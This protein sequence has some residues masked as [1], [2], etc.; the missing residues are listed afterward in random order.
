M[1]FD[2]YQVTRPP[3]IGREPEGAVQTRPR[4]FGSS[5]ARKTNP[6]MALAL[7]ASE[8]AGRQRKASGSKV[9]PLG[10]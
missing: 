2:M 10:S 1:M 9:T 5:A 7:T 8:V 3:R 6:I 4:V